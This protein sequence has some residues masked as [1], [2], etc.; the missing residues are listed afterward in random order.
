MKKTYTP[1]QEI[2][3]RYAEVMVHYGLRRGKGIKKGDV[4]W[5][6]GSEA[7]KPLTIAIRNEILR[8]GGHVIL[9]YLPDS[10][11]RND[12]QKEFY[13]LAQPHQLD[14]LPEKYWKGMIDE[15]DGM[16]AI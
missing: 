13:E 9:S 7:S 3:D 5:L 1:P 11:D 10:D 6:R 16:I 4:I 8:S 2:I 15:V 12:I 14:F